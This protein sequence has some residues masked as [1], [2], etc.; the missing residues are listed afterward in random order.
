LLKR[1]TQMNASLVTL[2][3][4]DWPAGLICIVCTDTLSLKTQVV[5]LIKI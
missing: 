4:M 2:N 3:T 5:K 1:Y